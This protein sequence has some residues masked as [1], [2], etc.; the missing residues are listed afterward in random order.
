[1]SVPAAQAAAARAAA[2]AAVRAF[3][4]ELWTLYSVGVFVTILRTYARIS[5]VGFKNL[6][7]DDFL[8][9][10]AIVSILPFT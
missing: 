1:M 2:E 6:R 4:V 3:N 7:A 10:L 5:Q 8:I 9:W